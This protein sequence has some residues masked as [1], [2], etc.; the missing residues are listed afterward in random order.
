M[1]VPRRLRKKNK[2]PE[3]VFQS[4][5]FAIFKGCAL[6]EPAAMMCQDGHGEATLRQVHV[7]PGA[8][9]S[10]GDGELAAARRPMP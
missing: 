1:A 3:N 9:C 2:Q 10:G 8:W 6:L 5:T 7:Q 4:W